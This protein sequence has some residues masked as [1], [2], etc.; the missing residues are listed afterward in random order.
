M[1]ANDRFVRV[2]SDVDSPAEFAYEV[3]LN[4]DG[5]PNGL[6]SIPTRAI[7]IGGS[8]NIYCRFVSSNNTGAYTQDVPATEQANVF[9]RAASSGTI[10]PFRLEAIWANNYTDDTANTT[11]TN[12]VAL[13]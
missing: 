6:L 4:S 7:Y 9:I 2:V 13:Y 5:V 1:A 11:A 10:L 12:L 8:G 3:P